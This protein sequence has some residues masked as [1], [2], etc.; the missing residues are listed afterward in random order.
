MLSKSVSLYYNPFTVNFLET[1]A[2]DK[3]DYA[4]E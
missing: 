1:F 4:G 2:K 3:T